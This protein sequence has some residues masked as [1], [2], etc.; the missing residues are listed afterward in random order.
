[1]GKGLKKLFDV[2]DRVPNPAFCEVGVGHGA[3]H[4]DQGQGG[5][6]RHGAAGP[7]LDGWKASSAEPYRSLAGRMGART[8]RPVMVEPE[9]VRIEDQD[10]MVPPS[11]EPGMPELKSL[12][13][14][15]AAQ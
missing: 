15:P 4:G 14:Q 1:M 6:A 7:G 2:R 11:L 10:V 5:G 9:V 3:G 13:W 8:R 12:Y